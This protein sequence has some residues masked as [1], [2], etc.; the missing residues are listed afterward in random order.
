MDSRSFP[1][2]LLVG[3]ALLALVFLAS[4]VGKLLAWDSTAGYMGFRGIPWPHAFLTAAVVLEI[5]GSLSLLLGWKARCGAIMLA[6]MLVPATIIFHNFWAV[7]EDQQREQLLQ[8][9]KNVSIFGGLL[10][11]MHHAALGMRNVK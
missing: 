8:F 11:V 5:G 10:L 3:R 2:T 9:L 6:I 4:G 1:Y 7:P